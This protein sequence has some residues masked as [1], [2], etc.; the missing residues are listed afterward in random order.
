MSGLKKHYHLRVD[1]ELRADCRMWL[2]F[3]GMDQAVSRPFMDFMTVLH[4]D[5]IDFYTDGALDEQRIGVGGVFGSSWFHGW[6]DASDYRTAG[7][8]V[9]I[10]IVELYSILLGLSLWIERLRNR[11]VVIFCDNKSVVYMINRPSSSCRVCMIMIRMI[12]LWSMK[13]NTRIFATHIKS[14]DNEF[15]DPLSRGKIQQFLD[16]VGVRADRE[17]AELPDE[18]WSLPFEWFTL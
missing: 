10:Q 17:A 7:K 15:A 9:N 1:R 6:L 16:V 8:N 4:A 12:T 14:E 2:E 11:R 3:L 18:L 13:F 5:E